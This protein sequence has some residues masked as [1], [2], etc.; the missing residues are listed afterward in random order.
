[1]GGLSEILFRVSHFSR[2][3][4]MI[5]FEVHFG[6]Y[7]GRNQDPA[8]GATDP[9]S[10]AKH[11]FGKAVLLLAG[12]G[13]SCWPLPDLPLA[14]DDPWIRRGLLSGVWRRREKVSSVKKNCT[15]L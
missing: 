13:C 8:A 14:L 4:N 2:V 6:C 12:G 5:N 11:S 10:M 7:P 15:Y 3:E 9:S 1:M